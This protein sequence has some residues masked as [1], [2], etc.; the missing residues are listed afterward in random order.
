M[1]KLT[2][3]RDII[4]Q[5]LRHRLNLTLTEDVCRD[6][7]ANA[8]TAL[9]PLLEETDGTRFDEA[10]GLLHEWEASYTVE[11]PARLAYRTSKFLHPEPIGAVRAP[12][13]NPG[14]GE[15]ADEHARRVIK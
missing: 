6:A 8:A 2:E 11:T 9:I 14:D 1:S 4:L 12:R 13:Q 3:A 10:M 5:V 7:A 15:T